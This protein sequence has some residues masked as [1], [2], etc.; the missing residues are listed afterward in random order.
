MKKIKIGLDIGVASVGWCILDDVNNEIINFG[1][2]LFEDGQAKT[3]NNKFRRNKRNLRRQIRRIRVRK[4]SLINEFIKWG[5]IN[6]KDEFISIL[7]KDFFDEN[8]NKK[9]LIELRHKALTENLTKEELMA[10]L[11]YYV[12]N[13][14][15]FYLLDD[16]ND[17]KETD[18]K[19]SYSEIDKKLPAEVQ[20]DF[21]KEKGFYKGWRNRDFSNDNIEK[22]I[23]QIFKTQNLLNDDLKKDTYLKIFKTFR[24]YATGPGSEKSPTP[25]GLW[26]IVDNKEL[27]NKECLKKIDLK[28]G[29]HKI[30]IGNNLWDVLIGKCTVY[31]DEKRGG[32]KSPIAE[33]FNLLN[34]LNNFNFK[35]DDEIRKI[36]VDEKLIILNDL[37]QN[38]LK[39]KTPTKINLYYL[40]KILGN[41]K[42]DFYNFRI[43]KNSE[44]EFTDLTS[45]FKIINW[46][47]K[48]KLI[49]NS[50]FQ[51]S[52]N[53]IKFINEI[54]IEL[55]KTKN[56]KI[57][58]KNIINFFQ[59]KGYNIDNSVAEILVNDLKGVMDTHSLSYKAMTEFIKNAVN[60]LVENHN[61]N[62]KQL[63]NEK[64]Y[65]VKDKLYINKK[66]IPNYIFNNEI[67]S[68]TVKRS[69]TQ[70]LNVLNK[71]IK[72]YT[73]K[74]DISNI[75]IELAREKNS[76]EERKRILRQ[77]LKNQNIY[78]NF[79]KDNDVKKDLN[80]LTI[81]ERK[82]I[83]LWTCQNGI[84][85]YSGKKICPHDL[86]YSNDYDIDHIIPYSLFM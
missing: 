15:Y 48:N 49:N 34:D 9:I 38:A 6:S 82:K 39:K 73:K 20:F 28:N 10:I 71:I 3:D 23:N 27:E 4:N 11:F 17:K 80:T 55:A 47:N 31:S 81:K 41:K 25:Y 84:D 65:N 46:L 14:G 56:L 21:F 29:T 30:N 85:L 54:F 78:I 24:D 57:R 43:N 19:V 58:N 77:Q 44:E 7:N 2:R 52:L 75:F 60:E 51:F 62:Q 53:N 67:I 12:H 22:E 70:V 32:K 61:W 35:K 45:C 8:G 66:Y 13:R 64:L 26:R 50:D 18:K 86:F 42:E 33:I 37:F 59:T 68:S 40:S 1:V 72:I 16:E 5:W 36:F 83:F 74:Y 63:F 69:F 79:L 76:N